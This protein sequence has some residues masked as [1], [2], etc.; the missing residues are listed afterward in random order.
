MSKSILDQLS[1]A[2]ERAFIA[3]FGGGKTMVT[4]Y[5]NREAVFFGKY[6]CEQVD[7]KSVWLGK[8]QDLGLVKVGELDSYTAEGALGKP[9]A[10]GYFIQVT[11]LGLQTR[12]EYWA[13]L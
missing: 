2:E 9:K 4:K 6:E 7:F 10:T 5:D 11:E 12:E 13:E 3:W 8:F 1:H